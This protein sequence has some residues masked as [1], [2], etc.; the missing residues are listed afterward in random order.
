MEACT[1][2]ANFQEL[3]NYS[4]IAHFPGS[5]T[6]T[7]SLSHPAKILQG[8]EQI[9]KMLYLLCLLKA[10]R[11]RE[12]DRALE[13]CSI[14]RKESVLFLSSLENESSLNEN[15]STQISSIDR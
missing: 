7:V 6:F 4:R 5:S 13:R 14:L 9:L 2:C 3:G 10:S 11:Q 1:V 15:E 12:D 8:I